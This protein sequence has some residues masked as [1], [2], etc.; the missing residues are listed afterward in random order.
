[1][2]TDKKYYPQLDAIRGLSFLAVFTFH[3][4]KPSFGI[5]IFQQFLYFVHHNLPLSI[6]VF[7]VL[8]AFLLTL[9]GLKEYKKN[10]N[11]SF[12][13]YFIRRALRIW[14]LYYLLMF[15]TFVVIKIIAVKMGQQ[16]TLPLPYWYLFFISNY[17]NTPHVYFLKFLWTLSVEEQFYL[18]WGL[19]LL[20]FQKNLKAVMI[21]FTAVSIVFNIWGAAT[22]QH[23]YTNTITYIFDMMAGAYAAYCLHQNNGVINWIK[24]F[25]SKYNAMF[26]YGFLLPFFLI[27]FIADS[28]LVGVANNLFSVLMRFIFIIYTCCIILD[29]MV[30]CR[31]RLSLS[32][33]NFLIYTGKISYG[34]YCFHGFVLSFVDIFMQKMSWH[35][36]SILYAIILLAVTFLIASLS[37]RFIEKPFLQL[38]DK[39]RRI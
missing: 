12:K 3:A 36:P 10:G 6:D 11:F 14:P 9:L 8:S 31:K 37:Y 1:M 34:L 28:K 33:N 4:Y 22:N 35:L 32:N 13:N 23:I 15:L 18:L 2:Y 27:Y 16:I 29:Q 25:S 7:F 20:L 21:V 39:L 30:N 38:K 19:C 24:R 17:C 5:S 26:M